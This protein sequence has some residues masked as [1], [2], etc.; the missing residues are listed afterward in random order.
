MSPGTSKGGFLEQD[1]EAED[2]IIDEEEL[3]KLKTMKDLKRKYRE[4][5]N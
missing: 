4:A 2:E 3:L 1:E 5:F